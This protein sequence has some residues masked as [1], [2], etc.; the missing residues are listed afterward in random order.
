[1][2]PLPF[3][4]DPVARYENTVRG[5]FR[6]DTVDPSREAPVPLPPKPL[7]ELA[8][9]FAW[10][11]AP[12]MTS[13]EGPFGPRVIVTDG[14][15]HEVLNELE[16]LVRKREEYLR[17]NPAAGGACG[18]G[19]VHTATADC[20]SNGCDDIV[21]MVVGEYRSITSGTNPHARPDLAF[22]LNSGVSAHH[23]NQDAAFRQLIPSRSG[24]SV[25]LAGPTHTLAHDSLRQKFWSQYRHGGPLEGK[26]PTVGDYAKALEQSLRD[27]GCSDEAIKWLAKLAAIRRRL[28]GLKDSDLVPYV[29]Q[30]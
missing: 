4:Q 10:D 28:A 11:A 2:E 19:P 13:P 16:S 1:M 23:L 20:P 8:P 30:R 3:E 25:L 21:D 17:Q 27:A 14:E 5:N 7:P 22:S 15:L 6:G 24:V 12:R 26:R 9:G 18:N 29:P